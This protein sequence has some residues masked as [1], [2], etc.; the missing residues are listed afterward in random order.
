ML[1]LVAGK[2]DNRDKDEPT[3]GKTV[4]RGG[5]KELVEALQPEKCEN[6]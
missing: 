2:A 5:T 6:N 3:V 4:A 1:C